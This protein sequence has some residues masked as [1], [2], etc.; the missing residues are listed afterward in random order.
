MTAHAFDREE[1]MAY[2]DG[3]LT[4]SAA[5]AVKSHLE[6]CQEC[7]DTVGGIQ[8]VSNRLRDWKIEPVPARVRPETVSS[9]GV[10]PQKKTRSFWMS[11]PGLVLVSGAA[12]ALIATFYPRPLRSP[13]SPRASVE[14][15]RSAEGLAPSASLKYDSELARS[16]GQGS[17]GQGGNSVSR[18]A[19]RLE[20]SEPSP[21][22]MIVRSVSLHLTADSLDGL[23]QAI[24]QS[25]AKHGGR[26]SALNVGGDSLTATLRVPSTRLDALLAALRP[27]GKV[28]SEA[29]STDDVTAG[30]QDLSIRI[31][32]SKR[33]EQRL[34]Q[35]LSQRTGK[36]SEVLE[37]EQA[38]ARVRTEIERMEASLRST[39]DRVDLSTVELV[40][41]RN[42]RAEVALGP[43][44]IGDR[45]RNAFVDG[46]RNAVSSVVA[47]GTVLVE[48]AP[49]LAIWVLLLGWPV[50]WVVR[51][52]RLRRL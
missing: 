42:Y 31:A 32:N 19:L 23:R 34:V 33:E 40:I 13:F 21:G 47:A 30:Y 36:L 48:I 11:W 16:S 50:L 25:A 52:V 49:I 28:R 12:A 38:I 2:L 37:V 51:R 22:P 3:E 29:L 20:Q 7:R 17:Q 5:T 1:V 44:S 10:T 6:T 24:E 27:L 9:P 14:T 18:P 15:S 4:G 8:L 26:V 45:F 46:V 43:Q 35:L 41:G 39:K